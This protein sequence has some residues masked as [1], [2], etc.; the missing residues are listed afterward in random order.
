MAVSDA[1]ESESREVVGT[2]VHTKFKLTRASAVHR[3]NASVFSGV[4]SYRFVSSGG[5]IL[6]A[7]WFWAESP[8][9]FD[10]SF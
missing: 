9:H 10:M 4:V 5:S 1:V 6:L 8:F 3:Y 7:F 2:H